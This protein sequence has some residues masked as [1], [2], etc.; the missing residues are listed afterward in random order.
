MLAGVRFFFLVS[1][2]FAFSVAVGL[3]VQAQINGVPASVTSLGFGGSTNPSPG[4]RASVTSLGPNGYSGRPI[5]GNFGNCCN[6]LFMP[7]NPFPPLFSGRHH[8]RDHDRDRNFFPVGMSE[9]VFVPY[10]VPYAVPYTVEDDSGD[11]DDD[12][13]DA[14]YVRAPVQRNQRSSP[15]AK[16]AL[17]RE[18]VSKADTYARQAVADPEEPAA[19]PATALI[20]KDGH[21]SDVVN[22]AIVGDTLFDFDGGRTRKIL[23]AELDLDAT[24]KA[25][26]DRG[27]DFQIPA[28][29]KGQ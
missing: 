21:K 13:A 2:L 10:A 17:G 15:I 18:P 19:Q 7:A 5:F 20:F 22:Y 26:D 27:V 23:L 24:R 16:R 6:N 28:S 25:N 8:R 1:F 14:D 29:A 3:P 4:V 11:T 9:P 12:S